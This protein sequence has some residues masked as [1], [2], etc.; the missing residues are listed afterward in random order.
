MGNIGDVVEFEKSGTS[1]HGVKQAENSI[2]RIRVRI[3]AEFNDGWFE[4]LDHVLTFLDKIHNDLY[5]IAAQII[6]HGLALSIKRVLIWCDVV[7]INGRSCFI[8]S[9]LNDG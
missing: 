8:F 9:T 5:L 4:L 3:L 6:G 1:L 7:N 2:D